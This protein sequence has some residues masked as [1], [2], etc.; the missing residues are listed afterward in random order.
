MDMSIKPEVPAG[1]G[2]VIA[3]L[4]CKGGAGA[5]FIA[6]N[7]AHAVAAEGKRVCMMDLNLHFGEASLYV[8]EA[9]PPATIADLA[10]ELSRLDGALLESSMLKISPNCWLLAAPDSPERAVDIRADSIERILEVARAN[11]DV[12]V[13]DVSRALDA[14]S[15]KAL[16][17]ADQIYLVMQAGLP[18]I[19]D[20][21]RLLKLFRALAYPESRVQLLINR[22]EKSGDISLRDLEGALGVKVAKTL[23]NSFNTVA[24]AIN[25]G[26]PILDLAPRDP[27]S[28]ALREMAQELACTKTDDAGW[29]QRFKPLSYVT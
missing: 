8:S 9:T 26:M 24:V 22:Y 7:L 25:Q 13:L 5:T 2:T 23:P 20:G 10:S 6:T 1:H 29:L 14:P 12:V 3:V 15:I 27:V 16:D 17:C 4:P 18:Y 28:R 11:F 21:K 19:R